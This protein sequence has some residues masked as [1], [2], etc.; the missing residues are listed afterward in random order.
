MHS[1]V[2]VT[3]T[4]TIGYGKKVARGDEIGRGG[5]VGSAILK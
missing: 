1:N 4:Y 2:G 5:S 3:V